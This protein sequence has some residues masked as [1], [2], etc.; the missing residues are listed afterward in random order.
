VGDETCLTRRAG[1]KLA[2]RV[3]AVRDAPD[4]H[5]TIV[6]D[7]DLVSTGSELVRLEAMLRHLVMGVIQQ[8]TPL[9]AEPHAVPRLR[10]L[11]R[12][13]GEAVPGPHDLNDQV[14]AAMAAHSE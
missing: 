7:R 5:Q 8:V 14:A 13:G 9:T 2:H 1:G 12:L 6:D 11:V 3:L 4:V 10:Y